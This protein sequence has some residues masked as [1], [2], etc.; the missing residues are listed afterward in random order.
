MRKIC[1][2]S[3]FLLALWS[4]AISGAVAAYADCERPDS[5]KDRLNCAIDSWMPIG[6][7][8]FESGMEALNRQ[9]FPRAAEIFQKTSKDPRSANALGYMYST[10]TYFS[11][12][13]KKACSYYR[14]AADG[15]EPTGVIN[16][17]Y[18]CNSN[19]YEAK[20][21]MLR[22]LE[23]NANSPNTAYI[24]SDYLMRFNISKDGYGIIYSDYAK[25]SAI[26]SQ[27]G[28]D[29]KSAHWF[30]EL[31][32]E[33]YFGDHVPRSYVNSY[34]WFSLLKSYRTSSANQQDLS[35]TMMNILSRKLSPNSIADAQAAAITCFK[36][37]Y[38]SCD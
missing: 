28:S 21:F 26:I 30:L 29:G 15:F 4:L 35:E 1:K 11:K 3:I 2:F 19:D 10:G 20:S 17:W 38:R 31:A 14:A 9:S 7:A 32:F 12:D 13:Y 34:K 8:S 22:Q 25:P 37:G 18:T 36:R 33:Y 24:L 16:W 6:A 27:F 5:I 23:A